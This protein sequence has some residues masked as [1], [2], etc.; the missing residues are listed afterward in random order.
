MN[1]NDLIFEIQ[2]GFEK[3]LDFSILGED[4]LD[5]TQR[6]SLDKYLNT[7]IDRLTG[8]LNLD[9]IDAILDLPI[10]Y[11]YE[12]Q[13]HDLIKRLLHHKMKLVNL[14][15]LTLPEFY[16]RVTKVLA[17]FYISAESLTPLILEFYRIFGKNRATRRIMEDLDFWERKIETDRG[18]FKGVKYGDLTRLDIQIINTKKKDL[19]ETGV[20]QYYL[21]QWCLERGIKDFSEVSD[22][23]L[24]FLT[25]LS[26]QNFAMFSALIPPTIEIDGIEVPGCYHAIRPKWRVV[27]N[28]G[29]VS[30]DLTGFS[31]YPNPVPKPMGEFYAIYRRFDRV[32]ADLLEIR[33]K[34]WNIQLEHAHLLSEKERRETEKQ[35]RE[36]KRETREIRGVGKNLSGFE[37]LASL[38]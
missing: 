28:D 29:S 36:A 33:I 32:Y 30:T 6:F 2:G 27:R 14:S 4:F 18:D 22:D 37:G 9:Q 1:N 21:R 35:V 20:L 10:Y 8:I 12:R 5:Q 38:P 31:V 13:D 24:K 3:I 25:V 34:Q 16:Y 11:D 23:M 26:S 19:P 7:P 17:S 15:S